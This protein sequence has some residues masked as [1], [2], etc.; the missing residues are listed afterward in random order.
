MTVLF[1]SIGRPAMSTENP[2]LAPQAP[3]IFPRRRVNGERLVR[4]VCRENRDCIDSAHDW[5]VE[6]D[7]EDPMVIS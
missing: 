6:W 4:G 3:K 7:E 2:S 1:M 5:D